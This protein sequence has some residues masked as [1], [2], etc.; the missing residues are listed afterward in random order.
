MAYTDTI[1]LINEINMST[2]HPRFSFALSYVGLYL[3]ASCAII[4]TVAKPLRQSPTG[5]DIA[6]KTPTNKASFYK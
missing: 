2:M 3:E 5:F 4:F 1:P 6:S